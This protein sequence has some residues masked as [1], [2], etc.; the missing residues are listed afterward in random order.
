MKTWR[1]VLP[2]G[3]QLLARWAKDME[4]EEFPLSR[5]TGVEHF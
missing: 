5:G 3:L 1:E 2:S 4:T